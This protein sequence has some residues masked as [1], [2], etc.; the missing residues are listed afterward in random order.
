MTIRWPVRA[1]LRPKP[2]R[3]QPVDWDRCCELAAL[4]HVEPERLWPTLNRVLVH[5]WGWLL[6]E[7]GAFEEWRTIITDISL[8]MAVDLP[9]AGE[10]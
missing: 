7:D 8:Q 3:F 1:H 2:A 10:A 5:S 4:M 6:D 9:T